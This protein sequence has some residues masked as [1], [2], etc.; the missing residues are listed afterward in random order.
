MRARW[1]Q[2]MIKDLQCP[3]CNGNGWYWRDERGRWASNPHQC[4]ACDGTGIPP[5]PEV[6]LR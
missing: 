3:A 5:I 1:A 6:E 4:S 2:I